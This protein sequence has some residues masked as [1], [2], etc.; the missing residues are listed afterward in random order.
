MTW[1]PKMTA[2]L[3]THY[4]WLP[5]L[6]LQNCF[7]FCLGKD[8]HTSHFPLKLL[9][10]SSPLPVLTYA[11]ATPVW[12]VSP[13]LTFPVPFTLTLT[14]YSPSPKPSLALA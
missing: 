7:S 8:W 5:L 2:T 13:A 14:H 1:L 10:P 6:L 3:S 9:R 11:L 4:P 12:A